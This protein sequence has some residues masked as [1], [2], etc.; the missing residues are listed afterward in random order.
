MFNSIVFHV[1]LYLRGLLKFF[2]RFVGGAASFGVLASFLFGTGNTGTTFALL[3]VSV[4]MFFVGWYY[5]V[6][7]LRLNPHPDIA[8][9]LE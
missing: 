8:L 9:I 1:M 2:F 4:A 5:D 6:I 7:L 3:L